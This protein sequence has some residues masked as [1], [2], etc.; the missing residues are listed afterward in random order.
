MKAP[1]STVPISAVV[2]T[3]CRAEPLERLLASLASQAALPAQVI[4]VDASADDRTRRLVEEV[5]R[6]G[7]LDLQYLRSA[8]G[9][10]LQRNVGLGLAKYDLILFL[11]DDT[12]LASN[13][14]ERIWS[15]FQKD[16]EHSIGGICGYIVNQWGHAASWKLRLARRLGLVDGQLTGGRLCPSGV[17]LE[18]DM[19]EPFQGV[20][21]VDFLSGA[22]MC[23]RR[24]VFERARPPL[25][26]AGYAAGEDKH[27][28]LNVGQK[29]RV[30]VC[31]DALLQHC[32]VQGPERPRAFDYGYSRARNHLRILK[33]V[34]GRS[35]SQG[36]WRVRLFYLY[37]GSLEFPLAIQGILRHPWRSGRYARSL[38]SSLGTV[39]AVLATA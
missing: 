9:L 28:S 17:F 13:C 27:L 10:T 22:S 5:Q 15:A 1:A 12:V 7:S 34:F 19:L 16:T 30:C 29:W 11:D 32:P 35:G 38:V 14:V 24:D 18:L 31:G 26:L 25:T 20:R 23:Y 37:M 21:E 33:D 36:T 2:A 8:R 6:S 4:I 3:Y 39:C